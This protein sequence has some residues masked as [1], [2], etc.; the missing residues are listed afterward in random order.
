[1][2]WCLRTR[3]RFVFSLAARSRISSRAAKR[4]ARDSK[5]RVFADTNLV[6][7]SKLPGR[8]GEWL[9]PADCKSAAP[10]GLRRFESFP[11]HQD[12][13]FE[14]KFR[15]RNFPEALSRA[16]CK[17]TAGNRNTRCSK[18]VPSAA[19]KPDERSAPRVGKIFWRDRIQPG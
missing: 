3:V 15:A 6:S 4:W 11:V 9:K 8:V 5:T 14:K 2:G 13:S 1:M 17:Y 16:S 10:C 12:S 18:A 7:R 19:N